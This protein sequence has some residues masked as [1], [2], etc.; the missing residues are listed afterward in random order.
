MGERVMDIVERLR[1]LS[2]YDVPGL[3]YAADEIERLRGALREIEFLEMD[4]RNSGQMW[5]ETL[6][7]VARKALGNE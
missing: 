6:K 2:T 1:E 5:V 4:P 7:E 3:K